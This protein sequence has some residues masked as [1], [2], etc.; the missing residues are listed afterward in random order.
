MHE[1]RTFQTDWIHYRLK[2]ARYS[3]DGQLILMHGPFDDMIVLEAATGKANANDNANI[4]T[5]TN[6]YGNSHGYRYGHGYRHSYGHGYNC[7]NANTDP[8][9]DPDID[10]YIWH[11]LVLPESEP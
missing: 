4:N 8:N 7:G 3:P 5:D 2:S 11:D 9:S 10:Q 6:G 1:K